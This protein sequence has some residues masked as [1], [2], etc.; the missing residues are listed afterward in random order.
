[1]VQNNL[2]IGPMGWGLSPLCLTSFPLPYISAFVFFQRPHCTCPCF[3]N[4]DQ[5]A[6]GCYYSALLCSL[7]IDDQQLQLQTGL[8]KVVLWQ[9]SH[10]KHWP[11][12][13]GTRTSPLRSPSFFFNCV[14][15]FQ[16]ITLKV[17]SAGCTAPHLLQG[18]KHKHSKN[19]KLESCWNVTKW[20]LSC[21][22]CTECS[23]CLSRI[24]FF[25]VFLFFFPLL[26]VTLG[27]IEL[28]MLAKILSPEIETFV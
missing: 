20:Q 8:T 28:L 3:L 13:F 12:I 23:F 15:S 21:F 7:F 4:S 16:T 9:N 1:M 14:G 27:W 26:S 11:G 25:C 18:C 2:L 5:L 22:S 17:V 19:I 10:F 24:G 6:T